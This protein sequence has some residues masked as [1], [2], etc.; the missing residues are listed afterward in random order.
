MNDLKIVTSYKSASYVIIVLD[1]IGKFFL[2]VYL[3]D[4]LF[5]K[6]FNAVDRV[7][8]CWRVSKAS[9]SGLLCCFHED[10]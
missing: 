7:F 2:H 3:L 10:T 4:I 6:P 1:T 5:G 9:R 8:D